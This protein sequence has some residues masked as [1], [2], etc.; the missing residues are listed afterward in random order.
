MESAGNFLPP[1][2]CRPS[3]LITHLVALFNLYIPDLFKFALVINFLLVAIL[4]LLE[5]KGQL[6]FFCGANIAALQHSTAYSKPW[7]F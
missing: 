1:K 7:H 6:H 5:T 3:S 4:L 2:F